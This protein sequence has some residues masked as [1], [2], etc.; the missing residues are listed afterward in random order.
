M[1]AAAPAQRAV[2]QADLAAALQVAALSTTG[3][4]QKAR[5]KLFTL[6]ED[7]CH[8]HNRPS[9]LHT[10]LDPE[11]KILFLLVFG[12]QYRNT[13]QKGKPV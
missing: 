11:A 1:E 10:V 8:R 6:W 5:N 3:K 13:G 4:T 2:F 7:F 9:T 12:M